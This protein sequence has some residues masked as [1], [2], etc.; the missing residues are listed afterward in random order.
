MTRNQRETGPVEPRTTSSVSKK[1]SFVVAGEEAGSKA[2]KAVELKVPVIT[3]AELIAML[4]GIESGETD[5]VK[6]DES[7]DG[8]ESARN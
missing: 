6:H 5:L 2:E 1:T 3:E 8:E 4:E 7:E